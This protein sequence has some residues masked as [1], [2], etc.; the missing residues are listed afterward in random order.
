MKFET[1][2][3]VVGIVAIPVLFGINMASTK[4]EVPSGGTRTWSPP[5]RTYAPVPMPG[6]AIRPNSMPQAA[7]PPSTPST[8]TS[9]RFVPARGPS[10][11][12]PS[13]IRVTRFR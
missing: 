12:P 9:P 8:T 5:P 11:R 4:D 3:T 1:V 2:L 13:T 6:P 7:V 10:I